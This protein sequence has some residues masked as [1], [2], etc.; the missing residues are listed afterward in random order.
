MS[1]ILPLKIDFTLRRYTEL[2]DTIN[3]LEIPVYGIRDWI[4]QAPEK[5]IL[6]RHDVDRKASNSLKV[7]DIN[8]GSRLPLI[9]GT[10]QALLYLK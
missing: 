10:L 6:I 5:G 8:M 9:L 1:S 3:R 2:L 4:E 7:A